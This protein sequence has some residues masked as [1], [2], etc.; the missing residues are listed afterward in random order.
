MNQN[1]LKI[2]ETIDKMQNELLTLSHQI[3]DHPELGFEEFQAVEAISSVLEHHGFQVQKGYGGLQTAFRADKAGKGKGPNVAF[4]AEYDALRGIG[5]GC[6][7][8]LIAT[9]STGA[10]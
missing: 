3:H 7:H 1:K 4:L 5:H 2:I 10:F 6:G 9:C 8:N